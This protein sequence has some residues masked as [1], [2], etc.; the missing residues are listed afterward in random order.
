MKSISLLLL[1][2]L[3][4]GC[5]TVKQKTNTMGDFFEALGSGDIEFIKKMKK[6][7]T[8]DDEESWNE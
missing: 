1:V 3:V 7:Q 5:G 8:T 6:K 2:L 4:S